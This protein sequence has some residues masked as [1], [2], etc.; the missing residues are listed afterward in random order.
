[1]DGHARPH[2]LLSIFVSPIS[3]FDRVAANPGWGLPLA[4]TLAVVLAGNFVILHMIGMDNVVRNELKGNPRAEELAALVAGSLAAQASL[5]VGGTVIS[6]VGMLAVGGFFAVLLPLA[7]ART[8]ARQVLA[9]VMYS[10]F[11][12][13]CVITAFILVLVILVPNR[14]VFDLSNPLVSS[15]GDL[16]EPSS[17][18]V[19][20]LTAAESIDIFSAGFVL[21]LGTGLATACRTLTPRTVWTAVFCSW[22]LYVFVKSLAA[23]LFAF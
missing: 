5:Y 1:M 16:L 14:E 9:V 15:L 13:F 18:H 23:S 10:F 19:S 6:G 21:L 2:P 4:V 3:T 22:A 17:T 20:L 7:G 8:S 12:Y 11:V